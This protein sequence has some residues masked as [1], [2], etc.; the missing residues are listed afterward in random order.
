MENTYNPFIQ[1]LPSQ[2]ISEVLKE[3][4]EDVNNRL[5][6]L[7]VWAQKRR[8]NKFIIFDITSISSY[9]GLIESVEWGYNRDGENLLY[10]APWGVDIKL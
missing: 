8:D 3:L 10:F 7:R 2:R 9:S 1:T 5:K 6:F 4:G